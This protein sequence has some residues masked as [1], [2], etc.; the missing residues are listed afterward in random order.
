M[1]ACLTKF[2]D[3]S[4]FAAPFSGHSESLLN[5]KP[6]WQASN[7]VEFNLDPDKGEAQPCPARRLRRRAKFTYGFM[8]HSDMPYQH[9]SVGHL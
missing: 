2:A 6:L 9:F 7:C 5:E 4:G 1:L 8:R 3:E